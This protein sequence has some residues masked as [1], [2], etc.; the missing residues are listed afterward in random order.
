MSL[1]IP[2]YCSNRTIIGSFSS[3]DWFLIVWLCRFTVEV[4]AVAIVGAITISFAS[5]ISS[6]LSFVL[7][8]FS[9]LKLATLI[10]PFLYVSSSVSDGLSVSSPWLSW[11]HVVVS[12]LQTLFHVKHHQ[13]HSFPSFKNVALPSLLNYTYQTFFAQLADYPEPYKTRI[14]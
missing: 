2:F 13:F 14:L 7:L 5:F 8:R 1:N 4:G 3:F 9:L 11:F 12:S 10:F 6:D